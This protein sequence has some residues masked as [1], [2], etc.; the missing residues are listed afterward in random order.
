MDWRQYLE[1][2]R[3]LAKSCRMTLRDVDR[4]LWVAG[5]DAA[6]PNPYAE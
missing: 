1:V 6:L 2:C 4:A 5:A 3:E